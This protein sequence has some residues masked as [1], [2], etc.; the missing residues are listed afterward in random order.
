MPVDWRSGGS[1]RR[2][3]VGGGHLHFIA[4][5]DSCYRE[6]LICSTSAPLASVKADLAAISDKCLYRR[7]RLHGHRHRNL[8]KIGRTQ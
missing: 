7:H 2:G 5:D 4:I 6:P 3:T 1:S 8:P